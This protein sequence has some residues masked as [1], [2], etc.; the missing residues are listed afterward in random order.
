MNPDLLAI[1]FLE[2]VVFL[3]STTCHEAGHALV[4]MWGGDTMALEGG[5][6]SLSPLPHIKREPFGMVIVP[7][8]GIATGSG[9][10]GWA[11][12]PYN[13]Q[14]AQH[15][16]KRAAWMSLAGPVANF[17]LAFLAAAAMRIGL[18]TGAFVPSPAVFTHMVG[19]AEPGGIMDGVAAALSILFSLNILLGFFNFL[20]IPPLDGYGI[21]GIFLTERGALKLQEWRMKM[22]SA[23]IIGL[24]IAWQLFDRFFPPLFSAAGRLLYLGYRFS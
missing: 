8:L 6:V 2:Y 5:Q 19:A 20:P 9:L 14:W 23:T 24:V 10:I 18:A 13:A 12:T 15:Y 1:G 7:L 11:S 21:L 17:T 22:R 4:A 16:P 3:F